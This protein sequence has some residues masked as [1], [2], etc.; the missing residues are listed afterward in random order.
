M[1]AGE[2]QFASHTGDNRLHQNRNGKNVS[3]TTIS[4]EALDDE[5]AIKMIWQCQVTYTDLKAAFAT[6][7]K[8]LNESPTPMYVV[9]DITSHPKLPLSATVTEAAAG[10]YRNPKLIEWLVIG[11]DGMARL[12]ASLLGSLTGRSNVQWFHSEAE[13]LAYIEEH[14]TK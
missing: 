7:N 3:Q 13:I 6:I 5:P 11:P 8:I 14:R 12:I 2:L 1:L 4:V 9:V 10:S